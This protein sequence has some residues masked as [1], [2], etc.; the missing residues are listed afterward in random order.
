MRSIALAAA[1]MFAAPALACPMQ[2]AAEFRAAA[3]KVEAADGTKLTLDVKGLTCGDCSNKV[4]AALSGVE[5]VVAA[6]VD[7]QTGLAQIAFDESKTTAKKLL[8]AVKKSGY[9]ASVTK[10]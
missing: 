5:G 2:D 3:E 10:S 7:Y 8:A 4:T 9:E 6:A 1:L